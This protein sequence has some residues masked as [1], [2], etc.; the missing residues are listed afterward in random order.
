MRNLEKLSPRERESRI[1]Y[2]SNEL[3]YELT[4]ASN[5]PADIFRFLK[6]SER[7]RENFEWETDVDV[8]VKY[9]RQRIL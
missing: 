3:M 4:V 5:I 8:Q 7:E 6:V 1:V 9:K 2:E